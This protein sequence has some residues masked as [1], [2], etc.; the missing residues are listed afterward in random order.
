LET[1]AT[2]HRFIAARIERHFRDATALT[3]G[4]GEHFSRSTAPHAIAAAA[5]IVGAHRFARLSAIGTAVRL[6]L[7]TLLLVKA[8]FAG[9]KNELAPAID[10]V[11]RFIYVH[12]VRTP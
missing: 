5:R 1:I 9:T 4:R 8:L 2:I 7:K 3:A 10:T 6:V 11:E 12:E